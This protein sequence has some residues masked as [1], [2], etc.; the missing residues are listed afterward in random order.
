[1]KSSQQKAIRHSN[2]L[3][4]IY[5][6]Q[7]LSALNEFRSNVCD[8]QYEEAE[9][10]LERAAEFEVEKKGTLLGYAELIFFYSESGM[11][12]KAYSLFEEA[13]RLV[14]IQNKLLDKDTLRYLSNT[15]K[16]WVDSATYDQIYYRYFPRMVLVQ[17]NRN[18]NSYYI[19]QTETTLWQYYLFSAATDPKLFKKP[20]SDFKGDYPVVNISW[21]EANLYCKWIS[22]KKEGLYLIPSQTEWR[23]AAR[24][25]KKSKGYK[26]S[27]SDDVNEVAWYKDNSG[28]LPHPVGKK[29]P[30]ELNLHDMS[31]NVWELCRDWFDPDRNLRI[32]LGGSWNEHQKFSRLEVD[33]FGHKNLYEEDN[34]DGFRVISRIP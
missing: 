16:Q 11:F 2:E 3:L 29:K 18:Q 14:P 22:Q 34:E 25:G 33:F 8:L 5:R 6:Q 13:N 26:Y 20:N 23:F 21:Q 30:N 31:G 12:R 9:L 7:A 4:A 19:A 1:M 10:H 24:G 27:G 15:I 17:G 32:L 28:S